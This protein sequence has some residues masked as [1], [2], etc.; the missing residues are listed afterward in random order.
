[1]VSGY[2]HKVRGKGF[3][4]IELLVF[5]AVIAIPAILLPAL[6]SAKLNAQRVYRVNNIKQLTA[7]SLMYMNDTGAWWTIRLRATSIGIGWV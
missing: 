1:M 6:A 4:L 7:G 3:T 2:G 5:I